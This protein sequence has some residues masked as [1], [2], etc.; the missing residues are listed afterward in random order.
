MTAE[1]A[2]ERGIRPFR[3]RDGRNGRTY[4]A[5]EVES[6]GQAGVEALLRGVLEEL[7]PE[8]PE[9]V[10]ERAAAEG[11]AA[12]RRIARWRLW[13]YHACSLLL[14]IDSGSTRGYSWVIKT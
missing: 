6:L 4:E 8:D 13:S 14:G 7:V 9:R 11:A 1:L 3:K 2:E 10:R 12:N 5:I